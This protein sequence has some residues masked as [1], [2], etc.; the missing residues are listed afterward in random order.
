MPIPPGI[1]LGMPPGALDKLRGKLSK[2][3]HPFLM[4]T[5]SD[6]GRREVPPRARPGL[7]CGCIT[8]SDKSLCLVN[9]SKNNELLNIR[10]TM[11]S[12]LRSV[13]RSM[14]R[15]DKGDTFLRISTVLGQILTTSPQ[16]SLKSIWCHEKARGARQSS[17]IFDRTSMYLPL[18][19]HLHGPKSWDQGRSQCLHHG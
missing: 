3:Q 10:H 9:C 15:F 11:V 1:N 5:P 19:S 18:F 4:G 7:S 17:K 14:Q 16:R 6:S 13:N 8:F 12:Q 2:H